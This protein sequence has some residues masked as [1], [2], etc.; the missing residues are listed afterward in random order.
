M[1]IIYDISTISEQRSHRTGL[2]R[3][4]LKTAELLTKRFGSQVRFSA[5]GSLQSLVASESVLAEWPASQHAV[6]DRKLARKL[7]NWERRLKERTNNKLSMALLAT[8][9]QLMSFVNKTRVVVPPQSIAGVDIFHSSYA[10]IPRQLRAQRNLRFI[11]TLHD[12]T[13]LVLPEGVFSER[14]R[15]ITKRIA[16]SI[17]SSDWVIC[18]SEATKRDFQD[19]SMHPSSRIA[20]IP[21][22]AEKQYFHNSVTAQD[23]ENIRSKYKIP[24]GRYV[25]SLSSM[26]PNKNVSHLVKCFERARSADEMDSVTLVMAGGQAFADGASSR[27]A[28]GSHVH[29]IGYV[30]DT[31][32]APLYCGATAFAFPSLYEGFGLP[33]L[34]AMQCGAPV[35]C[36]NTSSLPEIAGDAAILLPPSDEAEWQTA[37]KQICANADLRAQLSEKGVVRAAEY[38]WD[39]TINEL[40]SFYHRVLERTGDC[41][42]EF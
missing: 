4:T 14:Q 1:K 3:T 5:I 8:I 10:R 25:L 24:P 41:P 27:N 22:A 9:R 19:Y 17:C 7:V 38:S 6:P 42:N 39:R 21:W 40:E 30:D 32:L 28:I 11:L 18:V 23:I 31:D 33:V 29:W 12:L 36:S 13:P 2:A 37:I 34:E 16:D 35:I 20:V 15:K 26:A